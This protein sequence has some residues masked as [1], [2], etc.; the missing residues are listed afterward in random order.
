MEAHDPVFGVS[1]T[2]RSSGGLWSMV[3]VAHSPNIV[4]F[5]SSS[6]KTEIKYL[7]GR[8]GGSRTMFPSTLEKFWF[9]S[10]LEK[11]WISYPPFVVP[12]AQNCVILMLRSATLQL[13]SKRCDSFVKIWRRSL[14]HADPTVL[15]QAGTEKRGVIVCIRIALEDANEERPAPLTHST[16]INSSC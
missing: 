14:L 2:R 1:S 7:P 12:I 13:S 5:N 15:M 11:F 3:S 10:T 8:I 16:V 6:T 4:R 9:P